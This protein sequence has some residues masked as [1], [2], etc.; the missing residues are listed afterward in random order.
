[1]TD[2]RELILDRLQ[3][4]AGGVAGVV[5]SSRNRIECDETQLP[6]VSVLEGDEDI[7]GDDEATRRRTSSHPYTVTAT[8]QV[9]VRAGG[10]DAGT[11][12]N[13]LRA[14]IIKAIL[15]DE[16]LNELTLNRRG[17]RYAG[18]QST[19]HLARWQFGLTALVFAFKY[20]L[21]PSEL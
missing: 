19:M 12:I 3:L 11:K 9:L 14:A 17:I 20:A 15:A 16:Q 4:V 7:Q 8:P 1:M 6:L 18:M 2:K 10:D 21:D 5:T 13:T